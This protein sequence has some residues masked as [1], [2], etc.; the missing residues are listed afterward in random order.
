MRLRILGLLGILLAPA[1]PAQ[2]HNLLPVPASVVMGREY[3]ALDSTFVNQRRHNRVECLLDN[4]L[5][6]LLVQSGLIGN[7]FH[8]LFFRHGRTPRETLKTT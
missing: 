4:R 7:R 8:D 2:Q 6:L 3:L 5:D 1:L